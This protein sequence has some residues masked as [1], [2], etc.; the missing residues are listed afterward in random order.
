MAN[1]A[2]MSDEE[3]E[4]PKSANSRWTNTNVNK[5]LTPSKGGIFRWKRLT[6]ANVSNQPA[7]S[8]EKR[9][10]V[11]EVIELTDDEDEFAAI[12]IS[13][14]SDKSPSKNATAANLSIYSNTTLESDVEESS[15]TEIKVY[16]TP[17]TQALVPEAS[18]V[19]RSTVF[20]SEKE[21]KP[22]ARVIRPKYISET[23]ND[24]PLPKGMPPV[25]AGVP[26]KF[27]VSPYRSQISVM[28]AVSISIRANMQ[29]KLN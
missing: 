13:D 23:R 18:V 22:S 21:N 19:K 12:N 1:K 9:A 29:I 5:I 11:T 24:A 25:I 28:N 15:T 8:D 27:P 16:D 26:V 6:P 20:V 7:Q 4:N 10:K 14:D 3:F 2:E 17:L